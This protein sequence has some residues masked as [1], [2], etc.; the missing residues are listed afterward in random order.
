MMCQ[1]FALFMNK[2][3]LLIL[4]GFLVGCE[5]WDANLRPDYGS[6]R[7]EQVCHPYGECSQGQWIAIVPERT[8][9]PDSFT[10]HKECTQ[11][12]D[13]SMEALWWEES[14]TRGLEIGRCMR[15][16]GFQLNP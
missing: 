7:A 15:K 4:L 9:Y 5:I 8:P 10:A 3:A 1:Y 16:L 6:S 14:V 13:Q 11:K 12:I 2:W